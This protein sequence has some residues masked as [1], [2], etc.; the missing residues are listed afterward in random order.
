M[1]PAHPATEEEPLAP[2]LMERLHDDGLVPRVSL[3]LTDADYCLGNRP[4]P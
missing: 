4:P 3:V 1:E 2:V